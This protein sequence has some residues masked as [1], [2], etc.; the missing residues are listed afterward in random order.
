MSLADHHKILFEPVAIG[1]KILRNRFYNV[2]HGTAYG[3]LR[4]STWASYRAVRAEGGWAAVSAEFSSVGP[5][6]D[7]FPLHSSDIWDDEDGR[8]H[9]LMVDSVH[10][11]GALAGIE[12][13]HGGAHAMR[14]VSREPAFSASGLAPELPPPA[15]PLGTPKV[16]TVDDIERIEQAFADAAVRARDVGYDI[17]EVLAGYGYLFAQFLS[18]F[19]NRRT[20]E[21][22][23][24]LEN[25]ARFWLETLGRVRDA[26][27]DDC[28]IATRLSIETQGPW[29][30][31]IDDSVALVRM[32]DPLVDLWDL[33][34]G[35]VLDWG[36]D[37]SPSRVIPE[38]RNLELFARVRQATKKPVVGVS[39]WTS[40]D[41]M[42]QA[43]RSGVIDIVGSARQSI[44]DPF[45]PQKVREGRIEDI[46]ECMG[47]NHCISSLDRGNMT[48]A[49]N[50]TA[51]EEYR[52]G[53]HPERFEPLS[54]PDVSVLVVGAGP[55]GM[56]AA[57]GLAKRGADMVHLVDSVD[58]L[59]GHLGPVVRLP[60]LREWGRFIDHRMI[61]IDKL[62]N[63]QFIPSTRLSADDVRDYGASHVVVATGARWLGTGL[64]PGTHEPL[65]GVVE[66]ASWVF[67]PDELL[68]RGKRPAEKSHVTVYDAEGGYMG[69]SIAQL[70]ADEGYKVSVVTPHSQVAAEGDLTLEGPAV[71]ASLHS[72]GVAM[73]REV[74]LT[75][76]RPE[77]VIGVGEFDQPFSLK[78]DA[79]VLVTMRSPIDDLYQELTIDRE[80]LH[81]AGIEAVYCIGDALSPRPLAE[82]MFDGHRL[83]VPGHDI[84]SGEPG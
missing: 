47:I 3:V 38:G 57:I 18:T 71:R 74:S 82:A 37:I 54:R 19:H 15:G 20:D 6:S 50:A 61:Q 14:R 28:A 23:G 66:G 31:S 53:W 46:R 8:R 27:G 62:P 77:G 4:P 39:R 11:H 33:N 2:P 24:S 56:E 49:Q 5:S 17:V 58:Q 75:S 79:L 41:L 26:V 72:S 78:S 83:A 55:A 40:P 42:A 22:G 12:L 34:V 7:E 10:R 32:A 68:V 76:A 16:M 60:G 84:G 52:R 13:H 63:L 1:P 70:L 25:R 80:A 51:G 29:G 67:T 65:Q 21:Y 45:F 43:V 9:K 36:S 69:T 30:H 59:G 44:A 64:T 48:C 73:Y 35:S 81:E